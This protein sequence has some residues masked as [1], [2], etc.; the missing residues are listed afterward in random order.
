[1]A[2][3]S[4]MQ[5]PGLTIFDPKPAMQP[6]LDG[7]NA[8]YFRKS[9]N[10]KPRIARNKVIEPADRKANSVI[11]GKSVACFCFDLNSQ[12]LKSTALG[13]TYLCAWIF[14]G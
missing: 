13:R 14:Y 4:L 2:L 9:K 5:A 6:D 8:V 3:A 10:A 1:M 7:S 12:F 11:F